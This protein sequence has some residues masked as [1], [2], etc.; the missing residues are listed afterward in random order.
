[1]GSGIELTN[2]NDSW[3]NEDIKAHHSRENFGVSWIVFPMFLGIW[4]RKNST[5]KHA[6]VNDNKF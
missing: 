2:L 6:V 4:Q 1:M 5:L 3:K